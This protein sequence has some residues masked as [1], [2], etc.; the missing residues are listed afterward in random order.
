M[1]F[2]L[3][4]GDVVFITAMAYIAWNFKFL[5][6]LIVDLSPPIGMW[7][8][9]VWILSGGLIRILGPLWL[10]TTRNVWF[11]IFPAVVLML[12]ADAFV[13]IGADALLL[14]TAP[15]DFHGLGFGA[16][17]AA[18]AG[19]YTVA[20]VLTAFVIYWF[21]WNIG[22][23]LY[24]LYAVPVL[25]VLPI[26]EPPVTKERKLSKKAI[27]LTFTDPA[28][29]IAAAFAFFGAACYGFDPNRGLFSIIISEKLGVGKAASLQEYLSQLPKVAAITAAFGIA[30]IISSLFLGRY[31]DK[32]GHRKGYYISLTSFTIAIIVLA[33]IP[34]ENIG[35]IFSEDT[36]RAILIGL[37]VLA[38]TVGFF[39]GFNFTMWEALLGDI[40][41]PQFPAFMFQYFMTGTHF[42][43]LILVTFVPQ[44]VTGL[45]MQMAL[46]V[47]VAYIMVGFLPAKFLKPLK[48]S[49]VDV[50]T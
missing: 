41:P 14:D 34:P 40:T 45:G 1:L 50:I 24:A 6:G 4:P 23:L 46:L 9:R 38:F 47:A 32:I 12:T 37:G 13:D 3:Y 31:A 33:L 28:I 25:A 30:V 17:W 39:E 49:K 15:P 44:L 11:G 16:G 35:G 22:F 29:F 48:T 10:I 8:R 2:G 20:T 5:L 21:G 18:R 43:A 26:K 27:A 42:S 36:Q 7:R 19:G